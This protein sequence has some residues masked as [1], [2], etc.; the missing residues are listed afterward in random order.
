[1]ASIK[2]LK[3]LLI[4]LADQAE[5]AADNPPAFKAVIHR[6]YL[7]LEGSSRQ[8]LLLSLKKLQTQEHTSYSAGQAV[9]MVREYIAEL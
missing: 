8:D 9:Q 2:K 6:I 7:L 1:V 5:V 3:A 4:D